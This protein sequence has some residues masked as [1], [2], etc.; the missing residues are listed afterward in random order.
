MTCVAAV[1]W[2]AAAAPAA[3]APAREV[4]LQDNFY[5]PAKLTVKRGATVVWR[6]PDEPI[7]VHDVKLRKGPKG[8]RR[9]HSEPAAGGYAFRRRLRRPGLYQIVCTLHEEMTMTVRV[10]R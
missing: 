10:R 3:A 5:L 1:A 2:C 4:V 6:W 9:F 7:D 8:V